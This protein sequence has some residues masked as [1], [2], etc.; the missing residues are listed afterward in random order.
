MSVSLR[1]DSSASVSAPALDAEGCLGETRIPSSATVPRLHPSCP[2][3]GP[4][5][6]SRADTHQVMPF[7]A[8][9]S[10]NEISN[11]TGCPLALGRVRDK[12]KFKRQEM[13]EKRASLEELKE[14]LKE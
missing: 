11:R 10:V 5:L 4:L 14:L 3:Q 6:Q 7:A 13:G 2:V 1:Q 9:S 8:S 12:E